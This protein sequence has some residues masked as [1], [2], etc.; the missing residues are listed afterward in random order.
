MEDLASMNDK[1]KAKAF[2]QMLKNVKS[3]ELPVKMEALDSIMKN[4]Y[5]MLEGLC[6]NEFIGSI[7]SKK[8]IYLSIYSNFIFFIN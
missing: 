5:Y 2:K 8:V 6:I 3:K 4:P 7:S 1:Q